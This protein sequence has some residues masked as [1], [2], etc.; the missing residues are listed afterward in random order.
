MMVELHMYKCCR[1]HTYKY[2][3]VYNVFAYVDSAVYPSL[4]K[5]IQRTRSAAQWPAVRL[6]LTKGNNHTLTTSRARISQWHGQWL[7][8]DAESLY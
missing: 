1:T 2:R 6:G 7:A 4:A 5:A 8:R 3:H